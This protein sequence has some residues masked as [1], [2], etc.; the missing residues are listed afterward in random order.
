[1]NRQKSKKAGSKI[2]IIMQGLLELLWTVYFEGKSQSCLTLR[3]F[4]T[5]FNK[6]KLVGL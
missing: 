5:P 3:N 1:M 6:D 2:F 4:Q